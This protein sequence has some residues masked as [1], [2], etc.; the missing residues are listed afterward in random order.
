MT[1][2]RVFI[3][4]RRADTS[5]F[6]G[7]LQEVI[8]ERYGRDSVFMDVESIRPGQDY[9]VQLPPRVPDGGFTMLMLGISLCAI[10]VINRRYARA[11]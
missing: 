4:Y 5:H 7:R 8:S 2:E 3:S 9:V 10:A 11:C 1:A 6:V